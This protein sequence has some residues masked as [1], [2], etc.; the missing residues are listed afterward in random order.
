LSSSSAIYLPAARFGRDSRTRCWSAG[1]KTGIYSKPRSRTAIGRTEH[2]GIVAV[3]NC[4]QLIDFCFDYIDGS[5][6]VEERLR[7]TQHLGQCSDCL[8]FFETYRR[9]PELTRE[10]LATQI[11][12]NVRESVRSFLRAKRATE[13]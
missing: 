10:A 1:K 8:V 11:P 4:Q 7:F 9:T 3:I 6:P 12:P 13:P 2:D 5:L